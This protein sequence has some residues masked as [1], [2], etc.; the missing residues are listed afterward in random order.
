M[1]L[2]SVCDIWLS[3]TTLHTWHVDNVS[4]RHGSTQCAMNH[5]RSTVLMASLNMLHTIYRS[6]Y[7]PLV[8]VN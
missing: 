6:Y 1:G 3:I 4:E 8:S 5:T 2:I 7:K